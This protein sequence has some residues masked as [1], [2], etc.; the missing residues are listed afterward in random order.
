[1]N[2]GQPGPQGQDNAGAS[3]KGGA[4]QQP[5]PGAQGQNQPKSGMNQGQNGNKSQDQSSGSDS[6]VSKKQSKSKGG[7]SGSESGDGNQGGGQKGQGAGKGAAGGSTPADMGQGASPQSGAGKSSNQPGMR[8]QAEGKTGQPGQQAG[9]GST[10]TRKQGRKAG[11]GAAAQRGADTGKPGAGQSSAS[12]NAG[13]SDSQGAGAQKG[14]GSAPPTPEQLDRAAKQADVLSDLAKRLSEDPDPELLKQLNMSPEEMERAAEKWGDGAQSALSGEDL[15]KLNALLDALRKQRQQ[16][17]PRLLK[18]TGQSPEQF[19]KFVDGLTDPARLEQM[20]ADKRTS[21]VLE[22]LDKMREQPDPELLKKLGWSPAELRE[23]LNRWKSM[24]QAAAKDQQARYRLDQRL[25]RLGLR[26]YDNR[27]GLRD[28][29]N[30]QVQDLRDA[31]RTTPPKQYED[32]FNAF[33]KGA[34]Q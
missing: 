11:E 8:Q 10:S 30:D 17:D 19:R 9:D 13:G 23:F 16:P 14:Q 15:T 32:H 20:Y 26:A 27:L 4:S 7:E 25:R 21:L 3:S 28:D 18:R 29:R 1:M 2:S 5:P 31:D 22:K 12:S 24:K 33:R 6:S 34:A